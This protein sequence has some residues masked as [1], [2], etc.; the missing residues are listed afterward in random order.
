MSFDLTLNIE[1]L[2]ACSCVNWICV[3]RI[4]GYVAC[5]TAVCQIDEAILSPVN[6][7]GILDLVM[8]LTR[9]GI[10]I[11]AGDLYAVVDG[12]CIA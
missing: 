7:P 11:H 8:P 2:Y 12:G 5:V 4:E 3:S 9:D 10:I 1:I 6:P